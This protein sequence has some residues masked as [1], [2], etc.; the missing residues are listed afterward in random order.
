M[1]LQIYIFPF[2]SVVIGYFLA[3][4]LKPKSKKNLKLLLAFSGSFLLALTVMHLLPEVYESD[5]H[6]VEG[7]HHHHSS[8]IGIL[9]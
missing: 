2:L 7:H 9:L 3:L 1:N 5:L 8:P 6:H 4:F